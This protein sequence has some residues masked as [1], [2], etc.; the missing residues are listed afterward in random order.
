MRGRRRPLCPLARSRQLQQQRPSL[1]CQRSG[2][3]GAQ[4][5]VAWWR[6]RCVGDTWG[7]LTTVHGQA[8]ARALL[9]WPLH[10]RASTQRTLPRSPSNARAPHTRPAGPPG[11]HARACHRRPRLSRG[12]RCWRPH[13]PAAL[14]RAHRAAAVGRAGPAAARQ[15]RAAPAGRCRGCVGRAQ[16]R[17]GRVNAQPAQQQQQHRGLGRRAR[18]WEALGGRRGPGGIAHQGGSRRPGR[19]RGRAAVPCGAAAAAAHAF[20]A[21]APACAPAA[22]PGGLAPPSPLAALLPRQLAQHGQLHAAAGARHL[23]RLDHTRHRH[24][25]GLAAAAAVVG[26]GRHVHRCGAWAWGG[27]GGGRGGRGGRGVAAGAGVRVWRV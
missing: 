19:A 22:H 10:T 13:L 17:L 23:H 15:L 24:A 14:A 11:V 7:L 5:G 27:R 2:C 6:C 4:R 21:R 16:P 1:W 3:S 8:S 12:R 20:F 26:R 25:P 9:L 18:G